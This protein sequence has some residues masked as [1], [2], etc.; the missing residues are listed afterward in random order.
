MRI[1]IKEPAPRAPTRSGHLLRLAEPSANE[2]G[3]IIH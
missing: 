3:G 2:V 1:K